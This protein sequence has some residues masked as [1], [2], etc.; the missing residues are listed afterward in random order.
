MRLRQQSLPPSLLQDRAFWMAHIKRSE[1]NDRVTGSAIATSASLAKF[2]PPLTLR[3]IRQNSDEQDNGDKVPS[4]CVRQ[5]IYGTLESRYLSQLS[6]QLRM[7]NVTSTSLQLGKTRLRKM[8]QCVWVTQVEE[9][10]KQ[11]FQFQVLS[12]SS[13]VFLEIFF[14]F[15]P[16]CCESH[17]REGLRSALDSQRVQPC[18][19]LSIISLGTDRGKGQEVACEQ[20]EKVNQIKFRPEA[21]LTPRTNQ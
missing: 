18:P 3:F 6:K 17:R 11:G 9:V 5:V 12:Q 7:R 16:V 15:H 10:W 21:P 20:K 13:T 1:N 2:L 19:P 8:K 14:P 4:I